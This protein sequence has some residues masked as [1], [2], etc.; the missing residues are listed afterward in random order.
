MTRWF[1]KVRPCSRLLSGITS[2]VVVDRLPAN[3]W[4]TDLGIHRLCDLPRPERVVQLC[5]PDLRN[6]FPPLRT[7]Q[8]VGAHNL[9][10]QLT[11]FVGREAEMEDVRQLLTANRLVTLTGA[12]GAGK[13]R[14]AVEI[15]ARI[16]PEFRD[17]VWYTD[18][19]PVTDPGVV[20]VTEARALGLPDQPVVQ[21]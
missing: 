13:T 19:A 5:H 15:A 4:L 12:G 8:S 7:A 6:E 18:L 9:P 3:A 10:V 2:D 11:S 17:A 21:L 14:L 20:P 16:T 1:G